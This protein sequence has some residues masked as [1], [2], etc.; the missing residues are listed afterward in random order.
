M[1]II[2]TFE[3]RNK[4]AEFL[5][6]I[7]KTDAPLVVSRFGK[8]LVKIIPYK[9]EKTDNFDRFF[10][11]MGNDISGIEFENKVRRNKKEKERTKLLRNGKY[12][13]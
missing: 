10:G 8:P 1:R 11:F 9:K 2:S 3:F 5:D 13:R 12:P 7:Y 6:E 4:L